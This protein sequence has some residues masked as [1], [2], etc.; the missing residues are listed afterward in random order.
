MKNR[1]ILFVIIFA[2]A[3]STLACSVNNFTSSRT[4]DGNGV[5]VEESREVGCFNE[6][7]LSGVGIVYVEYGVEESLVI[8]AEENLMEYFEIR[9]VGKK[10]E[11]GMEN[12]I[13]IDPT[14]KISFYVTVVELEGVQISGLGSMNLPEVTADRFEIR[15][16]GAGDVNID[17]LYAERVTARL[18]GLGDVDI[19]GGEVFSQEI[20]IS[21][22]GTYDARHLQSSE[23][24]VSVSGLG[25]ATIFAMDYLNASISGA[26][27]INYYGSPKVEVDISGL[28]SLNAGD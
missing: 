11:I 19:D 25:S 2:L 12:N 22:S 20:E 21:G 9:T 24:E 5:L 28:G 10:L 15:I 16:S 6:I 23:T 26:G 8:E 17:A 27:D 14:E 13:S 3:V 18:S 7:Q 4:I 1:T